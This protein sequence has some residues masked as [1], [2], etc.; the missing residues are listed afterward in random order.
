MIKIRNRTIKA[1]VVP[2]TSDTFQNSTF[3]P[4]K[5]VVNLLL[6]LKHAEINKHKNFSSKVLILKFHT[7]TLQFTEIIVLLSA[8]FFY[9]ARCRLCFC[10]N[11]QDF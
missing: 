1:L 6:S 2:P 3:E 9:F 5:M 11:I 4:I 8:M 10:L 7:I